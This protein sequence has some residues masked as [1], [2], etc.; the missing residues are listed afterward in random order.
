MKGKIVIDQALCKGCEI[1]IA[2]CPRKLITLSDKLN[3]AGY[4]TSSFNEG[5]DCNG[6]ASCG[7]V[8]PEVA[9]EVY[10]E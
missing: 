7:V 3:S 10:R 2:F 8:C 4:L 9:I 5:G 6:C 1:C